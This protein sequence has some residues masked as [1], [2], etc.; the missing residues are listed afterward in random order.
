MPLGLLG[1][2]TPVPTPNQA[3]AYDLDAMDY[4]RRVET[5]DGQPLELQVKAAI[6]V[7]V[8]GCKADGIWGAIKSSCVLIGP[9]T[10]TGA[11]TPLVGAAPTNINFVTADYIRKTGLAG[12]GSSK[13]LNSNRNNNADPQNN[14]HISVYASALP[15]NIGAF[16][17]GRQTGTEIGASRILHNAS[18][19]PDYQINISTDST[20]QVGRAAMG[21]YGCSRSDPDAIQARSSQSTV[22]AAQSS[23]A[24]ISANYGIFARITNTTPGTYSNS[25]LAFYSIGEALDLYLLEARV[26]TLVSTLAA[27]L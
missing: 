3:Y 11:L 26:S 24:P 16:V 13:Y 4:I 22:I 9:R 18:G 7:F 1:R 20:T 2:P 23:T 14:K 10:L 27:V 25:R 15:T 12:N 5:A 17:A 8:R 19:L 6:D 21:F